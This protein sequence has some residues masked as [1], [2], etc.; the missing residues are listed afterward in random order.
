MN[1]FR[2]AVVEREVGTHHYTTKILSQFT[3]N[4]L[5]VELNRWHRSLPDLSWCRRH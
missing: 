1:R 2:A 3:L 5:V 4:G